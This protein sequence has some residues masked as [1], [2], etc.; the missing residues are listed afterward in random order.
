ML[1]KSFCLYF[2]YFSDKS[3]YYPIYPVIRNCS[4]FLDYVFIRKNIT[5]DEHFL[6]IITL[7]CLAE[8]TDGMECILAE[9]HIAVLGL[10][11]DDPDDCGSCIETSTEKE[12]IIIHYFYFKIFMFFVGLTGF[13]LLFIQVKEICSMRK[14]INYTNLNENNV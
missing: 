9:T 8:T 14:D 10:S 11:A 1:I 7:Q 2:F 5:I 3:K 13:L 4:I 12:Y 6:D